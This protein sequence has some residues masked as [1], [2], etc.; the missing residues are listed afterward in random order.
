MDFLRHLDYLIVKAASE[1][2]R[3][4]PYRDAVVYFFAELLPYFF[5]LAAIGIYFSGRTPRQKE[6]AHDTVF[7][8][9]GAFLLAI[10]LVWLLHDVWFRERPFVTHQLHYLKLVGPQL[11]SFPSGHAMMLFAP[12]GTVYFIGNFPKWGKIL[13]LLATLVVVA[14]VFAGVHYLSDVTIG[15]G[16]GIGIGKLVS[17]Q[18]KSLSR[19][20]R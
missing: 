2:G 20:M 19:D 8:M 17:W 7:A 4:E 14:R 18:S 16:L 10:G 5:I 13:L 12:A 6:K 9:V 3:T 11:S 15:A 1:A